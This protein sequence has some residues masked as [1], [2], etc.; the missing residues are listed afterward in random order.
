M[1]PFPSAHP[2]SYILVGG[3]F[4]IL[5]GHVDPYQRPFIDVSHFLLKFPLSCTV[6]ASWVDFLTPMRL[7]ANALDEAPV[8]TKYVCAPFF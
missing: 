6:D 7:C 1:M 5:S 3:F 8:A 2:L 4:Q